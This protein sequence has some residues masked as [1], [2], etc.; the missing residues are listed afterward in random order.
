MYWKS[1]ILGYG[2]SQNIYISSTWGRTFWKSFYLTWRGKRSRMFQ[3]FYIS[4][5]FLLVKNI[6]LL[7]FFYRYHTSSFHLLSDFIPMK[8]Y[9]YFVVVNSSTKQSGWNN[10]QTD[11]GPWVC[12]W[13]RRKAQKRNWGSSDLVLFLVEVGLQHLGKCFV[14]IQYKS[15]FLIL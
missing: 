8:W 1:K 6:D 14:V 3:R 7:S 15:V 13:Q 9:F 4:P 12:I 2:N 10:S 5:T 11:E